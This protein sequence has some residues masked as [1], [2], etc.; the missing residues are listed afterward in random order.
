MLFSVTKQVE[1]YKS[2]AMAALL[3]MHNTWQQSL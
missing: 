3:L 1:D 2:L